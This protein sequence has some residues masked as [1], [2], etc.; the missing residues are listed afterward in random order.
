MSSSRILLTATATLWATTS[1]SQSTE[2]FQLNTIVL[3]AGADNDNSVEVTGE[4]IARQ[5]PA[6]IDDLFK[7]EPTV[8]VGSSIPAS[9]KLYVNG[10]EETNLSVTIDAVSYTHLT[11]PTTPYV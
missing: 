8:S 2:P 9:Q 5:N 11:L 7:S 3:E 1:L 10:V 4:D 6:D